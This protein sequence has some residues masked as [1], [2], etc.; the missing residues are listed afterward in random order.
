MHMQT[1]TTCSDDVGSSA[2]CTNGVR[3]MKEETFFAEKKRKKSVQQFFLIF[4][5]D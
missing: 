2:Q 4:N 3:C 1:A 5:G